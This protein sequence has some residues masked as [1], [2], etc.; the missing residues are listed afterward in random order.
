MT[1]S[2]KGTTHGDASVPHETQSLAVSA[3]QQ[4]AL[5]ALMPSAAQLQRMVAAIGPDASAPSSA[6]NH[7][8]A[9]HDP[10]ALLNPLGSLPRPI[11]LDE[12]R[13]ALAA[14]PC[15]PVSSTK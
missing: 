9:L 12:V 11:S 7:G 1:N 2:R 10:A 5:L 8:A 15:A 13:Q 14:S 4:A 3:E 6:R